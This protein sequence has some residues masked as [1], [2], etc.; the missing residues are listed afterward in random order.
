M[1]SDRLSVEN[2]GAQVRGPGAERPFAGK[3]RGMARSD[4]EEK[5]N[6]DSGWR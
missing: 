5:R 3:V 1:S 6:V 2:Q 4:V